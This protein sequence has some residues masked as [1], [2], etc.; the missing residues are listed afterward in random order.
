MSARP[1]QPTEAAVA[2]R[3][4]REVPQFSAIGATAGAAAELDCGRD[5]GRE[6]SLSGRLGQPVGD[7][8]SVHGLAGDLGT[9]RPAVGVI[10]ALVQA[11]ERQRRL[12]ERIYTWTVMSVPHP[13]QHAPT[14][15][16]VP[17]ARAEKP[18][19]VSVPGFYSYQHSWPA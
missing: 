1:R 7:R 5:Q 3:A 11:L 16:W 19:P 10:R 9:R 14:A 6:G 13:Q 2:G 8:P 12:M 17:P 15:K 18:G 4:L